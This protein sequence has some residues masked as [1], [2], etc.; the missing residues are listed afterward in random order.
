MADK[1]ARA[2]KATVPVSLDY[3]WVL[4]RHGIA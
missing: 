3:R 1:K 4:E 2:A